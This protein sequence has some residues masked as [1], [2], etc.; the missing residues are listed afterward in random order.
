RICSRGER[1]SHLLPLPALTSG[2]WGSTHINLFSG[3]SA[4]PKSA[5]FIDNPEP[6]IA[7]AGA[8]HDRLGPRQPNLR[9][10]SFNHCCVTIAGQQRAQFLQSERPVHFRIPAASNVE[11]K[12]LIVLADN[13]QAKRVVFAPPLFG[14]G[15]LG[16]VV[17]ADA[18]GRRTAALLGEPANYF[19]DD[20][21]RP[22]FADLFGERS[23]QGANNARF[24][25]ALAE[26]G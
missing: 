24:D 5:S 26:D 14:L 22:L 18:L 13:V 8:F 25:F 11:I 15:E 19:T 6:K 20:S 3:A 2:A 4:E 10:E 21:A 1:H 23:K 7:M 17:A 16:Y 9:I 12:G